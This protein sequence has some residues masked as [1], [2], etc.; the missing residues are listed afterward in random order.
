MG[1]VLSCFP[2]QQL[3]HIR[4]TAGAAK[5]MRAADSVAPRVSAL[6]CRI[7]RLTPTSGMYK[8]F[9]AMPNSIANLYA[10]G[11]PPHAIRQ[12]LY[13]ASGKRILGAVL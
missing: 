4:T 5:C 12:L 7:L 11:N 6:Q 3:Y 9:S 1:R 8:G 2:Y 10:Y 13:P